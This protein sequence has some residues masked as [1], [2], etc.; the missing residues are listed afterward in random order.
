MPASGVRFFQRA[1]TW[2][3]SFRSGAFFR[4]VESELERQGITVDRVAATGG[5]IRPS[6]HRPVHCV[7]ATDGPETAPIEVLKQVRTD[8][9]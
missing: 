9:E 3:E 7:I 6:R 4:T 8:D 1:A 5:A 2:S